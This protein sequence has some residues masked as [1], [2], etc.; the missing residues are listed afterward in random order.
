MPITR[1]FWDLKDNGITLPLVGPIG[2]TQRISPPGHPG[3]QKTIHQNR[4]KGGFF[5][6]Y[7]Q[8]TAGIIPDTKRHS[9]FCVALGCYKACRVLTPLCT[10]CELES[11][12]NKKNQHLSDAQRFLFLEYK[13][14]IVCLFIMG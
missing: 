11:W 12:S 5:C 7:Q 4:R 10:P 6:V 2:L 8:K 3:P 9:F 1:T 14:S 13:G